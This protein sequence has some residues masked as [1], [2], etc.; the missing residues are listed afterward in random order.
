MTAYSVEPLK[1]E[2][3][4]L[5]TLLAQLSMGIIRVPG[6]QRDFVW[7]PAKITTLF[8]SIIKGYP[9]GTVFLWQAPSE[10]NKLIRNSEL[11]ELAT[12]SNTQSYQLILDGQQ[13]LTSLYVAAEGKDVMG[14]DYS[15]IVVDLALDPSVRGNEK[16][17]L[18]MFQI[19]I[20]LFL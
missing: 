18:I 4:R 14:E 17:L 6:F 15:H 2:G 19:I 12:P 1:P 11:F 16:F 3:V 13:R 10:Y 5:E 20:D 7:S 8:D 9:I